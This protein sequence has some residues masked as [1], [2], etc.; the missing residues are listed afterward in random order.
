MLIER[1]LPVATFEP[2]NVVRIPTQHK[3]IFINIKLFSR[4]MQW[5]V[6]FFTV[7]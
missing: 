3:I 6:F 4:L 5:Y 1:N 7:F 2:A